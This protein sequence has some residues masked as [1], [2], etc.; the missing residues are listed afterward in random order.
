MARRRQA[1]PTY[2][3]HSSGRAR[4]RTYDANGK[5]IDLILP[6]TYG[7]KQSKDAY[8]ELL[9][10][11]NAGGGVLSPEAPTDDLTIAELVERYLREHVDQH[12]RHPDGSPTSEKPRIVA[13]VKPLVRLFGDKLASRFSPLNLRTYRDVLISGTWRTKDEEKKRAKCGKYGPPCRRSVNSDV[14]RIKR[15]YRWAVSL[16]LVPS[17]VLSALESLAG[18]QPGRTEAKDR[19]PIQPVPIGDVEKT[20][21]KA[22]AH[23]ADLIR[24]QLYSGCRAGELLGARTRDIDQAGPGGTWILKPERHKASW[25]GHA[26]NIV[27]G[28]KCQLILRRYLTPD[29]PDRFLF[30]PLDTEYAKARPNGTFGERFSVSTYDRAIA[31]AAERAEVPKWSSHQL[32]HLA[33]RI[34]EQETGLEKARAFVGHRGVDMTTHYAGVDLEAAAE[35]AK[36]IG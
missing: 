29:E 20:I 34:A 13:A 19:P 15:M 16:C 26:R 32:R 5:R 28:P 14:G 2:Q 36:K 30:R 4:V 22:P 3:R 31:R 24:L 11:L 27:L 7:S 21:A 17:P 6:G 12:H 18:L 10:R 33:A 8:G 35:V 1:I 23:I 9:D 25:R